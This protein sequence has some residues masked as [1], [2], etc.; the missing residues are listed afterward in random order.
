MVLSCRNR[1]RRA[2][3]RALDTE[4]RLVQNVGVNHGCA[5]VFVLQQLL[6][7]TDIATVLEQ[8][9]SKT[10]SKRMAAS[11]LRH[12]SLRDGHLDGILEILLLQVMALGFV[13][14]RINGKL[15]SRKYILPDP[16]ASGIWILS[17][18]CV[19]Q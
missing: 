9:S 18:K 11:E 5:H 10:V 2:V 4:P 1:R 3:Q 12:P 13:R 6:H 19:G 14:A 8:M 15:R 17:A 16:G 7:I